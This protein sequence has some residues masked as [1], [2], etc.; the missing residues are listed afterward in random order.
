MMMTTLEQPQTVMVQP[1]DERQQLLLKI[2]GKTVHIPDLQPIFADWLEVHRHQISPWIE[3][4]RKKV[5][6]KIQ[7]L[8][9]SN[10]RQKQLEKA[11]FGLLTATWWP[12]APLERL[13]ILAYIII[14]LFTWDDEIDEPAG[15]YS[16]DFH[17]AQVYREQTLRFVERCLGLAAASPDESD[18]PHPNPIVQSFEAIGSAL[19]ACY[20]A[21]QIRRLYDEVAR[22]VRGT[23]AEQ[24]GRLDG[25]VPTVEEYWA[26]RRSTSAV[27][28]S[29]AAGEYAM[30]ARLPAAVMGGRAMRALW[31]ETNLVI[32]IC[33]DLVSLRKEVG[34]GCIESIVPLTFAA[35]NDI[36][37]AV[38][39]SVAALRAA[40]ERFDNAAR[41]LL[42]GGAET[43]DLYKQIQGFINI[44]KT[45]CVGNLTWRYDFH[46]LHINISIANS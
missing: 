20:D 40:K 5:N 9:F 3:P 42:A 17:G 16:E 39:L 10:A 36:R 35:T 44:Q 45:N 30:A 38:S 32:A 7:S 11:D 19:R 1:I 37:E 12:E 25:R 18:S 15:T 6:E 34:L 31:D 43:E 27:Y 14:W 8:N 22:F 21:G 33:N 26:L 24:R 28:I 4:L 29:T 41:D 2:R 23:E 46:S 13:C